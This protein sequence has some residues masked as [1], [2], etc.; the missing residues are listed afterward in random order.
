VLSTMVDNAS[1]TVLTTD[2]AALELLE[3]GAEAI[4][5]VW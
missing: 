2:G 1:M 3:V 5:E 4:T